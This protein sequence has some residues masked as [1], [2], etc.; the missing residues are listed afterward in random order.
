MPSSKRAGTVV[1]STVA[2]E[3]CRAFLPHPLPPDPPLALT[4]DDFDLMEKVNCAFGRLDGLATLLPDTSLFIYLYIRKEAVL[5]KA[6]PVAS[7]FVGDEQAKMALD[8]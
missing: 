8:L 1:S 6:A 3:E 2:G 4:A 5:K 7:L